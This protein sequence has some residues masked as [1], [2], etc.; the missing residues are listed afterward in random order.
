MNQ[1][2]KPNIKEIWDV[3]DP[4]LSKKFENYVINTEPLQRNQR[5]FHGTTTKCLFNGTPCDQTDCMQCCILKGGWQM[6]YCKTRYFGTGLYS[7]SSS[8]AACW[9]AK[10]N[11]K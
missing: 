8:S 7:T 9:N 2:A 10:S 6:K 1:D 5:R 3:H 11:K 4:L